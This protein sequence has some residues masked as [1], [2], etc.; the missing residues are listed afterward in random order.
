M[1]LKKDSGKF[2]AIKVMNKTQ[3]LAKMSKKTIL[4]EIEINKTI[5]IH[6]FIVPLYW[7]FQNEENLYLIMELCTGG[8]LFYFLNKR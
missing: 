1:G 4:T 7:T 3:L 6:P 5:E 2:Y 8:Q